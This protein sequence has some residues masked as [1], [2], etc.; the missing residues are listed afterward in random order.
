MNTHRLFIMAGLCLLVSLSSLAQS[1]PDKKSKKESSKTEEPKTENDSKKDEIKSIDE[2]TRKC[3]K[4]YGLFTMYQDTTNGKVYLQVNQDQ[5]GKEY[6]HFSQVVDG[7]SDMW[8]IRGVYNQEKIFRIERSFDKIEIILENTSYYF[9][10]ASPLSKAKDANINKPVIF[11]EKIAG[12]S[13]NG[14]QFLVEADKL[15]ISE[16]FE[17][18]KPSPNP[19]EKP[20]KSFKVGTLSKDKSKIQN[21]VNYPQNTDIQVQLVYEEQYPLH[22]GDVDITDARFVSLRIHNS[23]IAVPQNDYRPRFDDPRVGYFTNEVTNMT[24]AHP[25][26]YRDLIH[27]WHL[28][29]KDP[30][31]A[32]S[33]PVEPIVWWIENTTPNELRPY[34][35]DGVLQWNKAFEKAGFKNAI[36]VK[37]QPDDATWD[38]GDIRYNVLRWTSSPRPQFGGYGPS[39]VN[40]RTGQILGAD[41]M[42]EYVFVT[43]RLRER[44]LFETAAAEH[45]LSEPAADDLHA[46]SL[47]TYLHQS[48]MVG[49]QIIQTLER[50]KT[51]EEKLLQQGLYYLTLH[52]VGHTLG[53]NHNMKA[54]SLHDPSSIHDEKLT[55]E[56]GLLG[57][58]MDYPSVN[59]SSDP[60]K[61]GLYYV[62]SPGPY[63]NWAIEYGYKEFSQQEEGKKLSEILS[64][65]TEHALLF[66]ND[67]D[68]MRYPG[69]GIDPRVMIGDMSSDPVTY[70]V[71]RIKLVNEALPK[72]KDKFATPGESYQ[73]L[74]NAYLVLTSDVWNSLRVI[75]RQIGGVY[76]D[77]SMVGQPGAGKPYEP[78][79]YEQQKNAMKMLSKYGF[80]PE[81]LRFPND[82]YNM[83][84][85]Q[86]R[87]FNHYSITEDPKLHE[88][89]LYMHRDMLSQ[90]LHKNTLQ[91]MID[92]ELYGNKYKLSEYMTDLTDAIFKED[93]ANSVSGMRQ[94]LQTE[95][96]LRLI[97]SM[98]TVSAYNH[99]ARAQS[100]YEL[101]RIKAMLTKAVPQDASTKAH[102]EYVVYL[103]DD[104]LDLSK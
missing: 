28:K 72:L 15:F 18:L 17:Q 104:A 103:I 100:F 29:K 67:A 12:I 55:R 3:R 4:F 51:E 48:M 19:E 34:I 56:V 81:A 102:R 32:L 74:R 58:V 35:R 71:E 61:Q 44:Q 99:I 47:G 79:S 77:R 85:Q 9:D 6:I 96:T 8:V 5:L 26:P 7:P 50:D 13:K 76:V 39:F 2:V 87:G 82:L 16:A 43:N 88:R 54:S 11:R 41:I 22:H 36:V 33:E 64:R 37:E 14:D 1:K 75:C 42:L 70:C 89:T 69:Y 73:G 93:L 63:D 59:I 86:R 91:R 83:L 97:Q 68:D 49:R 24:S 98:N 80:S 101:K 84:Q 62:V 57:S 10:P 65:S 92:A 94:N 30:A 21:I 40:P 38:A 25:A 23:L 78:V 45:F 53:L 60:H 95:Y 46:C 52:E 31:A 66:G 20:G 90:L 27:R